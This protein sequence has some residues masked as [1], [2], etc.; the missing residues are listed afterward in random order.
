MKDGYDYTIQ[1]GIQVDHAKV[2]NLKDE[3]EM[4]DIARK[5]GTWMSN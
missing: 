4:K 3:R 2:A 1:I 5:I